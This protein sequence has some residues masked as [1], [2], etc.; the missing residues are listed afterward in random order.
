MEM[1]SVCGSMNWIKGTDRSQGQLLPARLEDYVEEDN[2]VR[3]VDAFVEQLDL[4]EAGF[5]HPKE[6]AQGRGR[7]AYRPQEMLKLYLYGY[8][9]QLRSSRRLERECRRNL[10]VMWLMGQLAPDFKTIADF[11]ANNAVAFKAVG[12]EFVQLCRQLGLFGRQ[13]LAI[14]GTKV[15]ASNAADR[16][17]S[18]KKL[19]RDRE[20]VEA[21][22]EEYL[23]GLEQADAQ[24]PEEGAGLRAGE[25]QQKIA[26]LK[27]RQS[28]IQE[29]IAVLEQSGQSQYSATD[30]DS[31]G[32]K[33]AHGHLVG[34]NV[35][36]SVDAKHHLLVT[37]E[38][39]NAPADQGQ[40]AEVARAAKAELDLKGADVVADGGYYKAEDIQACQEMG[41]EA[42][43]PAVENSPSE[44]AGLY[45]KNDFRYEAAQDVY[46]C[47]AQA[48]LTRRRV[49][50]DKGR[51]LINYD[52]PQACVPCRL[53]ARCT[54][55]RY[56]TVTRWEQEA[57]VERMRAAVAAAPQKLAAR[58]TLI[59]HCWATLK[60]LLPGGFL[61]RGKQKVAAEVSLAHFGY[62][63]K[64][65]LAVLGMEKMLKALKQL[66]DRR[67]RPVGAKLLAGSGVVRALVATVAAV[68]LSL[69]RC[70][71]VTFLKDEF[72]A[73]PR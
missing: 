50:E 46:R 40:L 62:N 54:Q 12:R 14:D 20:R 32:M 23:K 49:T 27:E 52:N 18:Q 13:L 2:P 41:L 29:R 47:P 65:A 35:Q 31:R 57:S 51:R 21:K 55:A 9:Y 1:A 30:P 26:R 7:P 66:K 17:W 15:K 64:R 60:W 24:G 48:L 67:S 73:P 44:R 38:V 71:A 42:H 33:G 8:L 28:Q 58:K 39:S 16:N 45:G 68:K 43:L 22:V 6:D 10:E 61:V 34:Y 4:R 3:F 53:K 36:G 69:R 5:E 11:R 37:A 72:G 25:L 63:L 70:F 59:E 56:R 19:L